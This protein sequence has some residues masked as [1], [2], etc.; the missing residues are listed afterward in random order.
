M[1]CRAALVLSLGAYPKHLCDVKRK[2]SA[3]NRFCGRVFYDDFMFA[4]FRTHPL[5]ETKVSGRQKNICAKKMLTNATQVKGQ[6][7][8]GMLIQF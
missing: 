4:T 2:I 3:S 8:Y 6:A 7:R 1:T 5:S